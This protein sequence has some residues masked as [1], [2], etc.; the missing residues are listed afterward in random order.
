V[1]RQREQ[2]HAP[3]ARAGAGGEDA[4]RPQLHEFG[5]IAA[6]GRI[7]SNNLVRLVLDTEIQRIPELAREAMTMLISQLKENVGRL[8]ALEAGI[9]EQCFQV[10]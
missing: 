6:Q 7:G 8:R 9:V 4:L 10:A 2:P 3:G 1:P 5:I